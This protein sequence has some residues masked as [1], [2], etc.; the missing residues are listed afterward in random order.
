[1]RKP[2]GPR[3]LDVLGFFGVKRAPSTLAFLQNTA[4][5]FGP[6]SYFRV[7]HQHTYFVNDPDLIKEVLVTQQHRFGRD[8]GATVLRELVGNG[9]LTLEEPRHRERR[10]IVQPAFHRDQVGS[11]IEI[12]GNETN[13]LLP[14]WDGRAEIDMGEEMR[15]L[16]LSIIGSSL[17]GSDFPDSA[18]QISTVLG[19]VMKRAGGIAPIVTFLK[20][21]TRAYRRFAPRGPSLFFEPQRKELDAILQPLIDRKR[22]SDAKDVL[23]LLLGQ[24]EGD[25]EDE[26]IRNE[27]VTFVLAGHE[28]TATALT[29]ACDL[30]A[31]EPELQ[32]RLAA[33]AESVLEGRTATPGDLARLRYASLVFNETLRL[34][35]PAPLFGRRVQEPVTLG[36]YDIPVGA[37]VLLSPYV[38][39][40]DPANFEA[41]EEFRPERWD[42]GSNTL[43]KFAFFPF[44][45]GAKMCIG[46]PLA[47]TEGVLILAELMRRYEF[48]SVSGKRAQPTARV[49]LRPAQPVLLR[50]RLRKRVPE[51]ATQAQSY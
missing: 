32:A 26:D 36:D 38:T 29:W 22:R 3:G 45:G 6:L 12:I 20:P 37:T 49:T 13:R 2:P 34:Y 14:G 18:G 35:P 1:M 46:E 47:R 17:F 48:E 42:S 19:R 44:G 8:V 24:T 7:F 11:Y 15:R 23:S 33:E 39:Q 41:P 40:R 43:P 25:L 30:L 28:T 16:T 5:K 51:L 9:V 21:I 31:A 50:A 10:R 4:R 27:M